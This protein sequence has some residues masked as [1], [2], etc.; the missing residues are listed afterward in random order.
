M[1]LGSRLQIENLPLHTYHAGGEMQA[2][3]C[4]EVLL[5]EE[6]AEC[7][8]DQGLMFLVSYKGRDRVRVGRL[9]SIAEPQR[10]LKGRWDA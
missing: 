5:T 7:I 1:R 4:A 6:A 3:P 10:P 2:K 8:L 9:Q